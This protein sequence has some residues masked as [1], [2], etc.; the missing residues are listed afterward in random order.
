MNA[1]PATLPHDLVSET[2]LALMRQWNQWLRG[3]DRAQFFARL[4]CQ[5]LAWHLLGLALATERNPDH[6]F[7]L[8]LAPADLSTE[9]WQEPVRLIGEG[10][11]TPAHQ[12]TIRVAKEVLARAESELSGCFERPLNTWLDIVEKSF[13]AGTVNRSSL[14]AF[15]DRINGEGSF[16]PWLASVLSRRLSRRLESSSAFTERPRL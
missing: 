7:R 2:D 8:E 6:V 5:E 9:S 4:W 14:G 3:E 11:I 1:L 13:G 16:Q 12:E 10:N 15:Y